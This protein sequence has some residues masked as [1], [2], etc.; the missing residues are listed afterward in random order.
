MKHDVPDEV[1]G[2]HLEHAGEK[3]THLIHQAHTHYSRHDAESTLP[4]MLKEGMKQKN[5]AFLFFL[6]LKSVV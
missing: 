6:V 5:V 2:S 1:I 3:L 4:S